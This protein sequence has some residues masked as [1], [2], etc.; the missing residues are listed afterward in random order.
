MNGTAA[1]SAHEISESRAHIL[2]RL[3]VALGVGVLEQR[4]SSAATRELPRQDWSR[5]HSAHL[6]LYFRTTGLIAGDPYLAALHAVK[7]VVEVPFVLVGQFPLAEEAAAAVG[8]G[9]KIG[10]MD[11]AG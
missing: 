11:Y 10:G 4:S 1:S 2:H 9:Q 8:A 5:V 7:G 3:S 6:R